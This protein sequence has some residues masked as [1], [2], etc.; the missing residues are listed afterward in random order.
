M[1]IVENSFPDLTQLLALYQSVGWLHSH[2]NMEFVKK[3]LEN[4]DEFICIYVENTLVA[5]GRMLTD[6][7]M[8]AFLDDIV[9]H[10]DYRR[11]GLGR[12]VIKHLISKVP[13]VKKVKVTTYYASGFYD[14]LGFSQSSATPMELINAF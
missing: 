10:S 4:S 6:Y 9:V 7:H 2:D 13:N 14:K 11:I 8:S 1:R 12:K 5:F 3:I